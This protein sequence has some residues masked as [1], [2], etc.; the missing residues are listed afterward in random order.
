ML[1]DFIE[2]SFIPV[3][4]LTGLVIFIGGCA[5]PRMLEN[6]GS[7]PPATLAPPGD[8][9][10]IVGDASNE[11]ADI[12][13][14]MSK[15]N[16]QQGDFSKFPEIKI[17]TIVYK[18]KKGDSFWKIARMYGVG[19]KELAAYNNMDLKRSL[20][21][22][23]ILEIPPGGK[24]KSKDELTPL[25]PQKT[26]IKPSAETAD[27]KN[28]YTVKPGDSLWLIAR[29]HNTNVNKLTEVNGI[30]K[31]A[32]LKVGQ[33]LILP[34]GSKAIETVNKKNRVQL[35][36]A[37][38]KNVSLSKAD[39]DLLNDLIVNSN[40]AGNNSES[41]LPNIAADNYLPHT[42]KEGDSWETISEMYG[43]NVTNLKKANPKIASAKNP[44]I[45]SVINIPEG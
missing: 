34:E 2:S 33:K 39:N 17:E 7:I 36:S 12:T 25:K 41:T 31:N 43:V 10:E 37:S 15:N 24:L 29:I 28:I 27:A 44:K 38:A 35:I 8:A 14:T 4:A 19:M 20:N 30:S 13:L 21:A 32:P 9:N 5:T 11:K 18:V 22:G 6:R 1:R 42:V 26:V 3:F 45:G 23:K 40:E 16:I